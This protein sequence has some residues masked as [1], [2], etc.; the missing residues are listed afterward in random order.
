MESVADIT[1]P[2]ELVLIRFVISVIVGESMILRWLNLGTESW[3]WF[4][5]FGLEVGP[6]SYEESEIGLHAKEKT[7]DPKIYEQREDVK[8][9]VNVESGFFFFNM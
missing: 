3:C 4:L 1:N 7:Y 9:S 2:G 8:H 6:G 5:G